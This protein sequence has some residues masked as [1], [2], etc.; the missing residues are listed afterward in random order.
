MGIQ[1]PEV[2]PDWP[3]EPGIQGMP[4]LGSRHKNRAP[5]MC[6]SSFQ[7]DMGDLEQGRGKMQN[8]AP[9]SLLNLKRI[10]VGP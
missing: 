8:M 9:A 3:P 10:A 7:G 1:T 2:K 5:D 6:S 4:L